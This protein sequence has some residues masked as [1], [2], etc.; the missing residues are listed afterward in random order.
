MPMV[1]TRRLIVG[2]TRLN[3][4]IALISVSEPPYMFSA[5][6]DTNPSAAR[7]STIAPKPVKTW[8]PAALIARMPVESFLNSGA[9]QATSTE[10]TTI[11][12]PPPSAEPQ[13]VHRKVLR[14]VTPGGR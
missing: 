10:P 13:N 6:T 7:I 9:A 2:R 11:S 8:S 3:E 4:S 12:Q 14:T 5:I 1:M